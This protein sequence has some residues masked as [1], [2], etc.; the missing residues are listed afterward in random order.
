MTYIHG[1]NL[2]REDTIFFFLSLSLISTIQCI[3]SVLFTFF[4]DS[5]NTVHLFK[6]S[7]K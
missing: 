6:K 7:P 5:L 4:V 2:R 1:N 3:I